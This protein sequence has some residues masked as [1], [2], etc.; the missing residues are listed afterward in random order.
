MLFLVL[1]ISGQAFAKEYSAE[2]VLRVGGEVDDNVQ[3]NEEEESIVGVVVSPEL[4]LGLRTERL[5]IALDTILDFAQ[6]DKEEFNSD[7]QNIVLSS[8][9][10]FEHDVFRASAQLKRDSTRTSEPED[11][12][13]ID[14]VSRR[15]AS[16]ASLSWQHLFNEKQSIEI[17]GI[18][19][20]VDSESLRLNDYEYSTVNA[21]HIYKISARSQLT[22]QLTAARFEADVDTLA[23]FEVTN[24][25]EIPSAVSTENTQDSYKLDME[26]GRQFTEQ[27]DF[28]VAI[29]ASHIK[30]S[31]D[32]REAEAIAQADNVRLLAGL[33][34][35]DDNAF[36]LRSSL[37][38]KGERSEVS[39]NVSSDTT[40]S[41]SGYLILSNQLVV[42]LNYRLS[43]LSD[44]FSRIHFI[45]NSALDDSSDSLNQ[46]QTSQDRTFG[47][48]VIGT[49]FQFTEAWFFEASYRYRGQDQEFF[50]DIA[51]SNAAFLQ[52]IYQ[53]QKNIW[54]R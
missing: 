15:E 16:S 49:R 19:S 47:S 14:G 13:L 2:T 51:T 38:Y 41:S 20:Q 25:G 48:I 11:T 3:L 26:I 23:L 8:G 46:S 31:F 6:F 28:S 12:G 34:D 33:E 36:F 21:A 24:L 40:P 53:P 32:S 10:A 45:D 39:L 1:G 17:G 43:K 5:D 29:G 37:R 18:Y 42:N 52:V 27:F 4:N 35:N 54:S 44:V 22:T 9:Y 50:D 7:D 30:Q